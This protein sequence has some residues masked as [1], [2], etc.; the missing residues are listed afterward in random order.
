[1]REAQFE[2][3]RKPEPLLMGT[4]REAE[5][6][7]A[8]FGMRRSDSLFVPAARALM[9]IAERN[10]STC[11]KV[12]KDTHAALVKYGI[13]EDREYLQAG[14]PIVLVLAARH[15]A[16]PERVLETIASDIET[17]GKAK[18]R[19]E[20]V[21]RTIGEMG[22]RLQ[23]KMQELKDRE[24]F[25]RRTIAIKTAAEKAEGPLMQAVVQIAVNPVHEWWQKRALAN[26]EKQR[27]SLE[28]DAKRAARAGGILAD[29]HA[30]GN[31]G[32]SI[33]A[34]HISKPV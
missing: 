2:Y 17:G 15:G 20:D 1:M 29:F 21:D 24:Q 10:I 8:D 25:A 30:M 9:R 14:I 12:I 7:L 19:R 4:L 16:S 11:E 23:K 6:A 31:E 13:P 26:A 5:Q 27:E 22:D 34:R 3:P 33:I 28:G 18:S 32:T